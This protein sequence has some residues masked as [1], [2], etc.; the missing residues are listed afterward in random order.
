MF[1]KFIGRATHKRN[2]RGPAG[3]VK[4]LIKFN[5]WF[6]EENVKKILQ[7]YGEKESSSSNYKHNFSLKELM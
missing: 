3:F 1:K 6:C 2:K 7:I 5:Y 4:H